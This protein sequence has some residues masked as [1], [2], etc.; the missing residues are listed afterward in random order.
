MK[1]WKRL[2]ALLCTAAC[3]LTGCGQTAMPQEP[4]R[5]AVGITDKGKITVCLIADFD[6]AYYDLDELKNMAA[7]EADEFNAQKGADA[8]TLEG[9]QLTGENGV[10]LTYSFTDSESYAAFS[11]A[12]FFYG[13][14]GEAQQKGYLDG[15]SFKSVKDGAVLEKD[16][17]EKDSDRKLVITDVDADIYLP[18]KVSDLGG[19]AS[20]N[21]DGSVAAGEADE[22]VYILLK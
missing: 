16:R 19:G 18:G 15:V 4:A 14:V 3:C 5:T 21:D 12:Q 6:R 22:L 20:L 8:V 2:T 17:L 10:Q 11:G 9:A 7:Q 13:T 1:K